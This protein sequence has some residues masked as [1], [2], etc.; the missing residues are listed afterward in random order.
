MHRVRNPKGD[1]SRTIHMRL[2]IAGVLLC[3]ST[4]HADHGH[5]ANHGGPSGFGAGVSMVAAS[6]D[7]MLYTGNYQGIVPSLTWSNERFGLGTTVPF[8]RLEKNGAELY[9]VGD[10]VVHGHVTLYAH[11]PVHAG[12]V[13]ALSVPVGNGSRGIGMGHPMLMPALFGTWMH[14]RFSATATAGYSRAIAGDTD[15]DHG[16]WPIVEPMNVSEVTWSA[17]GDYMITHAV[18]AGLHLSGGVP[19]G[20]GDHRLISAA[21]VAWGHGRLSTGG[22]LQVG[23]V[24]DPFNL[25]AVI[26]TALTF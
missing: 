25:R 3:A 7:T 20:N 13:A 14:G 23:L 15:H 16:M 10:I 12:I 6:F 24:G 2:W 4:A 18:T 17:G 26:S 8:Y 5:G 9:G 19:V 1:V 21:R 11:H 22:E